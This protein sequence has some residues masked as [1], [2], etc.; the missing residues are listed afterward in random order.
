MARR[1]H[2]LSSTARHQL[3]YS[4]LSPL[5]AAPLEPARLTSPDKGIIKMAAGEITDI[6]TAKYNFLRQD[7]SN[8]PWFESRQELLKELWSNLTF[9]SASNRVQAPSQLVTRPIPA[10]DLNELAPRKTGFGNCNN[11]SK[12]SADQKRALDFAF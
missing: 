6:I 1:V 11:L 8:E 2:L 4:T 9:E 12:S 5:P 3:T 7:N 10:A